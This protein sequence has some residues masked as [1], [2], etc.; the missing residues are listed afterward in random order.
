MIP[1]SARGTPTPDSA[2][3]ESPC[4]ANTPSVLAQV[5]LASAFGE[6]DRYTTVGRAVPVTSCRHLL[7]ADISRNAIAIDACAII[8][9]VIEREKGAS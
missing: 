3:R 8:D 5:H 9:K 2:P 6:R 4:H 1:T 7:F